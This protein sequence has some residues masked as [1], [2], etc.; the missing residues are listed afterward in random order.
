MLCRPDDRV[1]LRWRL[2][3]LD[4]RHGLLH[5]DTGLLPGGVP[6]F[7][8]FDRTGLSMQLEPPSWEEHDGDPAPHARSLADLYAMPTVA[9]IDGNAIR[10]EATQTANRHW[11]E[12]LDATP[13]APYRAPR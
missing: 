1:H 12:A 13:L 10:L 4:Q 2:L 11:W 7:L 9:M 6:R 3:L 5:A 8:S